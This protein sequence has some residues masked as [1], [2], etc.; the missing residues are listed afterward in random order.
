MPNVAYIDA[1]AHLQNPRLGDDAGPIMQ[2]CRQAG[3]STIV[4]NGTRPG[5]W[6]TVRQLAE[7]YPEIRPCYGLHPWYVNDVR[8]EWEPMLHEYLSD[9]ETVGLG[10]IG[11]DKWVK[12]HDLPRQREIFEIQLALANQYGL[13]VMVHCLRAWGTLL[14]S[15]KK[16]KLKKPFL[17]HSFGGPREMVKIF[18][19]LGAYFSLS[20]HFLHDRKR[21]ELETFVT[22]VPKD[23]LLMETDAP[24]MAPPGFPDCNHPANLPHIYAE[25]ANAA[26]LP[27]D[28][29]KRTVAENA[30]ALFGIR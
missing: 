4:V 17:L 25:Y 23:R 20:G 19:E 10:E 28:D 2:R 11:L 14:E 18:V 24:D 5:D 13:P 15:L 9:P 26:S 3:I 30:E 29:V 7:R 21:K 6:E 8:K 22:T 1:H 12:N 27:L 16:A